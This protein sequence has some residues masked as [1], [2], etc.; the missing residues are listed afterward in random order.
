MLRSVGYTITIHSDGR[1]CTSE[2]E[3][4]YRYA[5]VDRREDMYRLM[6]GSNQLLISKVPDEV[7]DEWWEPGE[8]DE[9]VSSEWDPDDLDAMRSLHG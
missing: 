6:A 9:V 1:L 2:S 8:G 7:F 4:V 5:G 3:T